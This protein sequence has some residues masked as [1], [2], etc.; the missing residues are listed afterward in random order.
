MCNTCDMS[1]PNWGDFSE[2]F[3]FEDDSLEYYDGPIS[4]WMQCRNCGR[5][6]AF[7]CLVIIQSVLWHW[8][9]LPVKEAVRQSPLEAFLNAKSRSGVSWLSV[10]EDRRSSHTSM[11][12]GAW[13]EGHIV[14]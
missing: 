13:V 11:C 12:S 1:V 14:I 9:L 5:R 2:R 4:G 10:I 8:S 6:F 7:N 3:I